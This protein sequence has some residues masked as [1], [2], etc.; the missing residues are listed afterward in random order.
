MC[1][2]LRGDSTNSGVNGRRRI[3]AIMVSFISRRMVGNI[4]GLRLIDNTRLLK[5]IFNQFKIVFSWFS[6]VNGR[7]FENP[8][9]HSSCWAEL[10]IIFLFSMPCSS[11]VA[12][13]RM[14]VLEQ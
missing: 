2:E 14:N 7:I 6:C 8:A 9:Q 13:C 10:Q 5:V 11:A 1:I 4:V 3:G 12:E